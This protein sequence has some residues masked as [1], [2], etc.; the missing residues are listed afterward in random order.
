M[1]RV[2]FLCTGNSARSQISEALLRM[3]G[4][5]DY[6]VFSAG[7]V[8]SDRVNP[9]AIEVLEQRGVDT[10]GL[11]PKELSQFL[12]KEFDLV[13][14]VCDN[15]KQEC[16]V[17]T[18]AKRTDHWF[19]EDPAALGGTHEEKLVKFMETRVEIERRIR[20]YLLK[21]KRC[22]DTMK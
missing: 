5:D 8:P 18:G 13:V 4:G 15:A 9:L 6:E 21:G 2:L 12:D 19:L 14:T 7:T 11:H 20:D 22:N 1:K 17:F 10:K 16:P 3:L